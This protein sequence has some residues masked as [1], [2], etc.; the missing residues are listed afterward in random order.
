MRG[1]KKILNNCFFWTSQ[2]LPRK[3]IWCLPFFFQ[4]I[5]FFNLLIF[6]HHYYAKSMIL[7]YWKS[8]KSCFLTGFTTLLLWK[9]MLLYFG[10]LG[11]EALW[12]HYC[13]L[14]TDF[15]IVSKHVKKKF[16]FKLKG[17]DR[18]SPKL[19]SNITQYYYIY[20]LNLNSITRNLTKLDTLEQILKKFKI[21]KNLNASIELG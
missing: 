18:F 15:T 17:F 13:L 10:F 2:R 8:C 12:M 16:N 1:K 20:T 14:K 4:F 21:L 7:T 11:G 5:T 6:R 19:V 3:N 9:S